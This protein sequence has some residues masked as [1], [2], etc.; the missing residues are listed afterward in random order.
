M[1]ARLKRSLIFGLAMLLVFA[2]TTSSAGAA[3]ENYAVVTGTDTLNLRADASS[4]S[5]WLGTYNRGAWVT[6]Y[7]NKNNFYLVTTGDG[8]TGYMSK[9]YLAPIQSLPYGNVAI[10]NNQTESAFLN[11]RTTPSFSAPVITILYNGVPLNILTTNNGWYQVQMGSVTGYVRSDFTYLSYQPLGSAVAT[12]KTPNNTAV[13]MR[14]GPSGSASVLWQF[15]GDRYVAVLSKG[16]GWWYVC[17]D[18]HVGFISSDYLQEG[19]QAARDIAAGSGGGTSSYAEVNNP[20]STQKLN[21]RLTPSTAAD[22]V[23]RLSNGAKLTVLR[24][25]VEWSQVYAQG[26]AATGYVMTQYL[27]LFNL[28]LAPSIAIRHP[29]GS[30]VNL[31]SSPSMTSSVLARIPDGSTVTVLIP[32]AD[33]VKI[34]YG[35][36]TG[37]VIEYFTSYEN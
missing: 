26:V 7:D 5:L 17:I 31:R 16:T 21:L 32:G 3:G 29:Q 11:L 18:G 37:Y 9:N 15:A 2:L 36:Q 30:Y 23:A 13:N 28:P 22:I 24:Q 10:V 1:K 33:W 8:K 6:I 12:I 27:T 4:S 34:Q 14:S 20:K 25:G 19:L 35:G